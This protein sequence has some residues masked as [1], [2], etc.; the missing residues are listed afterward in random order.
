MS[1]LR[2]SQQYRLHNYLE[3]FKQPFA[4]WIVV[5]R[6]IKFLYGNTFILCMM[7]SQATRGPESIIT[8]CAHPKHYAIVRLFECFK[9]K[10][11]FFYW[12]FVFRPPW[13]SET[14][15]KHNTDMSPYK[16]V[17]K[18]LLIYTTSRHDATLG[19]NL[20]L[21][22]GRQVQYSLFLLCFGLNQP[23]SWKI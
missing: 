8:D 3:L 6:G 21:V 4:V 22:A 15:N 20:S 9:Y 10:S 19:F 23:L 18:L 5:I 2:D 1:C 17:G 13:G 7:M 12:S 11:S 14:S 16:V